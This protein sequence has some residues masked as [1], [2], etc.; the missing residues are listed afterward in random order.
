MKKNGTKHNKQKFCHETSLC[1]CIYFMTVYPYVAARRHM[2][3]PLP[4][5]LLL[6][7]RV[8]EKDGG[9]AGRR[10]VVKQRP[11]V[12]QAFEAYNFLSLAQLMYATHMHKA[13]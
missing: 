11:D 3:T 2:R 13:C 6:L 5:L 12:R 4:L 8:V 10:L 7:P 1:Q 9:Q